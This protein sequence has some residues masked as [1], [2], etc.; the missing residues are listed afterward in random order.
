MPETKVGVLTHYFA[1]IG[2]AVIKTT[3]DALAV[4]DLIHIK[5]PNTDFTQKVESM[6]AEHLSVARL[7]KGGEAGLRVTT[8]VHEDDEVFKVLP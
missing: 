6:Q 8:R 1:R 3:D 2:V 4:G 7:E 5:G